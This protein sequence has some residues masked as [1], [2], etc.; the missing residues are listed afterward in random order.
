MKATELVLLLK[1]NCDDEEMAKFLSNLFI[2][3]SKQS[4]KWKSSYESIIDKY[5]E[6]IDDE[7]SL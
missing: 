7:E 3:E 5:Y 4:G 1:E 6:K 2:I